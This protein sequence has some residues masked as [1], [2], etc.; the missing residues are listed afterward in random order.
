[1]QNNMKTKRIMKAG[2][3]YEA[4]NTRHLMERKKIEDWLITT[5]E[6]ADL[7]GG[8]YDQQ[9]K[10]VIL[11]TTQFTD[12]KL[13]RNISRIS[14]SKIYRSVHCGHSYDC[15]GCLCRISVKAYKNEDFLTVVGKFGF[16]Y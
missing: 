11:D 2:Q 3:I 14:R 1:M 16:N 13:I 15:C 12:D 10:G 6:E 4:M 9:I 5:A 8:D 7:I